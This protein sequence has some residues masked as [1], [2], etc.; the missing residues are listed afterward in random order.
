MTG[1]KRL[2]EQL[3]DETHTVRAYH[4]HKPALQL[5]DDRWLECTQTVTA[6]RLSCH[7]DASRHGI[8]H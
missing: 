4:I 6:A 1:D 8:F 5:F 2:F 7:R 3:A